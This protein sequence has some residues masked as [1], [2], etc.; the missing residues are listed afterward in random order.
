ML[1]NLHLRKTLRA[2]LD[3]PTPLELISYSIK[4]RMWQNV[5]DHLRNVRSW[6]QGCTSPQ[7]W[8]G[9]MRA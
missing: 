2:T 3:T 1:A 6:L 4:K 8:Y 7:R 9:M 5:E